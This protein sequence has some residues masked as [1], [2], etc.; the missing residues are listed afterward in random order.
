MEWLWIIPAIP[1]FFMV[2]AVLRAI[3][4]KAATGKWPH[5]SVE[6]QRIYRGLP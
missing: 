1:L 2:A 5:Q 4:T 3:T 6:S